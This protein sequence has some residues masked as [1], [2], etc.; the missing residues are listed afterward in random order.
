MEVSRRRLIVGGGVGA[1]LLVAWGVWPRSY[2]PNLVA[3]PGETILGAFLKIGENG[4]VAVVVPQAEMGQ[5]VYTAL[6]QILADELGAD[7]RTVAVEP[8]PISPLYANTLLAEEQA[9]AMLAPFLQPAGEWVARQ[10]AIRSAL[11]ITGGST[12][13]RGF[14]APLRA[15]GAT[16]RALLCMAAARRWK[17]DWRACDT[18]AGF[19]VRGDDRLR[20]GELAAEAAEMTPPDPPMLR[21]AGTGKLAARSLPRL[22]LPAKLDGSARF[23]ADVRLPGMLFASVRQGPPGDTSLAAVDRAAAHSVPGVFAVFSHP[24]WVAA[25]AET[26]W[27]AERAVAALAPRFASAAAL[28][29]DASIAAALEQ[30]LGEDGSRFATRGSV[31]GALTN[32]VTA[33]YSV[34]FAPHAAIEPLCATAQLDGDRLLLWVPTQAPGLARAAAARAVGLPEARVTIY[35]ML[36][37]GGFGRKIEHDAV[38]QA[39]ILAV[40]TKRPVQL[41]WSR[42]EETLHDRMRPPA[43][44][45]LAA[46]LGRGGLIAAWSANIAAP[47]TSGETMRRAMPGRPFPGGAEAAAIDGAVPAYAIPALAIDHHPADIGV[48]TGIWRSVAHSY[49]AFFTESFVDELAAKAGIDPLSFRIQMLGDAPRLAN[50]LATVAALGGWEGGTAGSGQGLA[51]HS[52]F[53]SH[54]AMLVEAH[55]TVAQAVRVDRVTA[56]VDCGRVVN[57]DI[58][59]QQIEGGIVFAM[60][61]ALGPPIGYRRGLPTASSFAALGLPALAGTPAIQVRIVPS[62]RPSGGVAELAVPVVA[63]AIANALFAASGTRH[64]TLPIRPM[65]GNAAA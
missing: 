53:G 7:W 62:T 29:D 50:C 63:P 23:A 41:R 49:T 24:G 37:G 34:G 48:P 3:A 56:V 22:D 47:S 14:E 8:A 51:C 61:A 43:R 42:A 46:S 21:P 15:A 6:P 9:H 40:T 64:R 11:M 28:A 26:T 17:I 57:P 30:A 20:F 60:S 5:G 32:A 16:A 10:V 25:M 31:A 58:V 19:V 2:R 18:D 36:V 54:V 13:V 27:A 35:P 1:G 12:S 65:I 39:A 4:Q 45:R 59:A 44:A 52:A 38:A 55:V 33:N